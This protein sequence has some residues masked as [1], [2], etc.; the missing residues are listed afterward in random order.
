MPLKP[1]WIGTRDVSAAEGWVMGVLAADR[2]AAHGM[3]SAG[4]TTF[5]STTGILEC[6]GSA[7]PACGIW[8]G[9]NAEIAVDWSWLGKGFSYRRPASWQAICR[10]RMVW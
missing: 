10:Q 8:E 1:R 5:I 6:F 3:V 4:L 2:W 7:V 9:S